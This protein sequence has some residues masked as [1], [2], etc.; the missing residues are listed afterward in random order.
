MTI[1]ISPKM[2][3]DD[4]DERRAERITVRNDSRRG[5][6]EGGPGSH[7]NQFCGRSVPVTFRPGVVRTPYRP[8]IGNAKFGLG[9]CEGIDPSQNWSRTSRACLRY[10]AGQQL[11]LELKE[12]RRFVNSASG[13]C[14]RYIPAF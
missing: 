10:F 13:G 7:R 2:Q 6:Q 11:D 1:G 3:D 4:N 12:R 9:L 8:P 14:D 5:A